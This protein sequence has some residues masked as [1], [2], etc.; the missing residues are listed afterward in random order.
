KNEDWLYNPEVF[1]YKTSEDG[2]QS[3]GKINDI[4]EF[5]VYNFS[6]YVRFT[7][8]IDSSTDDLQQLTYDAAP[9]WTQK[10]VFLK[11]LSG[12]T[13]NLYMYNSK[14]MQRFFYSDENT[15]IT[16]LIYKRY[17]PDGDQKGFATNNQYKNQLRSYF[18]GTTAKTDYLE[19]KQ[20]SLTRFFENQ[21]GAKS[22]IPSAA[23]KSKVNL[24]IRPGIAISTADLSFGENAGPNTDFDSKISPR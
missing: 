22:D 23:K 2:A 24:Y 15:P 8:N 5:G 7:G 16:Q 6:K 21:N 14:D 19:Y 18:P 3:T 12:G 17:F 11:V 1:T 4:T 20:Q 13:K 10:T 9:K